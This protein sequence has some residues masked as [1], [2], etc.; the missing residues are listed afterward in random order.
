[1]SETTVVLTTELGDLKL[2]AM[3]A[4]V[5][6]GEITLFRCMADGPTLS[7]LQRLRIEPRLVDVTLC[8]GGRYIGAKYSNMGLTEIEA[9]GGTHDERW[10]LNLK[11]KQVAARQPSL[12]KETVSMQEP[13]LSVDRPLKTEYTV[14]IKSSRGELL[15]KCYDPVIERCGRLGSIKFSTELTAAWATTLRELSAHSET[16]SV[17]CGTDFVSKQAK[18]NFL[19]GTWSCDDGGSSIANLEICAIFEDSAVPGWTSSRPYPSNAKVSCGGLKFQSDPS[20]SW[21]PSTATGDKLQALMELTGTIGCPWTRCQSRLTPCTAR[22]LADLGDNGGTR[23]GVCAALYAVPGVTYAEVV[24]ADTC[25]K[26]KPYEVACIVTGGEFGPIAM[27]IYQNLVAGVTTLGDISM[28][29]SSSNININADVRWYTPG[30]APRHILE[31]AIDCAVGDRLD[32]LADDLARSERLRLD[33]PD[34][35][36]ERHKDETDEDFRV[37]VKDPLA[38]EVDG[39]SLKIMLVADEMM[40][41]E[42]LVS[43]FTPT[44]R[45]VLSAYW[46]AQLRERIAKSEA[47]AEARKLTVCVQVDAE[48][49]PW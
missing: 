38:M 47:E 49:L 37:R 27:A 1:M 30:S 22:L 10:N 28:G 4:L 17:S 8:G 24:T 21:D 18:I 40:R 42:G 26:L 25:D 46:S 11:F 32:E 15:L 34:L 45:S 7:D 41:Q 23:D 5:L 14:Q 19:R 9:N 48:D 13:Y 35:W 2:T 39:S 29:V 3:S 20:V 12:H 43:D 44:Q 33:S 16:F 31:A 36:L 6:D